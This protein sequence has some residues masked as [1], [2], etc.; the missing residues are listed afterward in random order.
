MEFERGRKMLRSGSG[1]PRA[2]CCDGGWHA[3][4]H[5][6]ALASDEAAALSSE[7]GGLVLAVLKKKIKDRKIKMQPLSLACKLHVKL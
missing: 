5:N 1:T 6:P 4:L 7:P 3:K 2:L